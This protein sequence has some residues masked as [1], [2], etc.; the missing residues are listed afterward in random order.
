L[1]DILF[2]YEG[3]HRPYYGYL[4]RELRTYPLTRIPLS[5]DRL[6]AKIDVIAASADRATQQELLA[7]V[8]A[9]L[10][11]DGF[12]DVFDSWEAKYQWMQSFQE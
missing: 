9:L 3:R 8:D 12:G 7:M 6:L 1:L 11:P 10:R 2:G 4:E 5:S